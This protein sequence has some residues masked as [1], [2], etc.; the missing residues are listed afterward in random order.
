MSGANGD[1]VA[2]ARDLVRRDVEQALGP[3]FAASGGGFRFSAPSAD[4]SDPIQSSRYTAVAWEYTGTHNQRF[5]GIDATGVEVTFRAVTIVDHA[6]D[7]VTLSRY[8]DWL[9]VMRQL[10]VP[11]YGRPVVSG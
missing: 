8:I 3:A 1:R 4:E 11:S 6:S 2:A 10:G 9:S 7:P 5:G